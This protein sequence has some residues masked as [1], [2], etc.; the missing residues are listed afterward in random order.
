MSWTGLID[1]A[2]KIRIHNRDS[3]KYVYIYVCVCI[4]LATPLVCM[5]A[6]T[7]KLSTG[8]LGAFECIK[9]SIRIMYMY[10]YINRNIVMMENCRPMED[11]KGKCDHGS[12]ACVKCN[13]RIVRGGAN[14][15]AMRIERIVLGELHRKA[16]LIWKRASKKLQSG[17]RRREG[18]GAGRIEEG[19]RSGTRR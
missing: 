9:K 4:Y 8:Q 13:F 16:S 6:E 12:D 7:P 17:G 1:I 10:T 3:V 15:Q 18:L 5:N 11:R 19:Q 14:R 2:P